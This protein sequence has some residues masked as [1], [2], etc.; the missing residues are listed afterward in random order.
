MPPTVTDVE[1]VVRERLGEEAFAHSQRTADMAADIAVAY[2]VDSDAARISA[3]LHDW[4]RELSSEQLLQSA[5][6]AGLEICAA[7]RRVPYLLHARTAAAE[8]RREFPDLPS[9]V[10]DAIE[11]HTVGALE[12]TPLDM[13]LFLADMLEPA[14]SWA[15]IHEVRA[16]VG[17]DSLETLFAVAY[18]RSVTH[19][20]EGA[21]VI[22]PDTVA[23]WNRHVAGVL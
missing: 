19:L 20:V 14:R 6:D 9:Q 18:K 10:S 21:R 16:R 15:G 13:V 22:H 5:D 4:D 7:D 2:G 17:V 11:R 23:V 8:L 12:M 1:R 3:L